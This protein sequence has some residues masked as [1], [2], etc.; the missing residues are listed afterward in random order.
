MEKIMTRKD[1]KNQ[2]LA[3]Q[4]TF[5]AQ[6]GSTLQITPFDLQINDEFSSAPRWNYYELYTWIFMEIHGF[7]IVIYV[8]ILWF[9]NLIGGPNCMDP[10]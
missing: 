5:G 8:S 3:A 6:I 2:A 7:C 10:N 1:P 9:D 4:P